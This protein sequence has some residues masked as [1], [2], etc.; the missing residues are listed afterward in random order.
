MVWA[1]D[2]NGLPL[3]TASTADHLMIDGN[4]G[5]IVD[6][7]GNVYVLQADNTLQDNGGAVTKPVPTETLEH[8]RPKAMGW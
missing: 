3:F 7:L 2:Q 5:D 1:K 6:Q 8:L 4:T